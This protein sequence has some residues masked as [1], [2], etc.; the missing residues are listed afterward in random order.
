MNNKIHKIVNFLFEV[1]TLRKVTRSHRQALLTNDLTDNI[2]S[3]SYRV[4]YIGYFLAKMEK[5]DTSK[6]MLMCLLHDLSESRSGDQNWIHKK[7]IK[8]FEEEILKDQLDSVPGANELINVVREYSERNS[9][10]AKLAKDADL[11]DQILL[12]REYEWVGN[13]EA[14]IWLKGQEQE[15]RLF[16][17]SAKKL[18]TEIYIQKPSS[19]RNKVWT[20]ERR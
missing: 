5:A 19:W 15:K 17:K 8:V 9:L 6:V 1:G 13:K 10:E 3:H 2:S 11:I 7:Y 12:L 4:S 20:A 16:S 14:A 18:A